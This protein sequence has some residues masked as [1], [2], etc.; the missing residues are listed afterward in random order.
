MATQII[1]ILCEGPHDVAFITRIL[2]HNGYSSNDKSK[3]KDFPAPINGL[4]KTE[5]S[6]T[7]VED[8]NL[9]E[10]RQVL[11]PSNSL[12]IGNNYFLLYS[13]GGD[14]KKAARQQLL[15][16]FY[17][18]IPKE[19]E[20]S[21]MPD[22]TALS[23]LY[24]FDSDDKGIAVRVA[25]L[26]EEILEIL[27]VSPFTN[28]KEKYNH[29]NLNLG[30]FIFSGADNDKG[31]LEDILMPL[32]SLDNDQIFAEASTYLDNNFD[33]GRVHKYDKDKSLIGVVGQLQHSG[34]SNAV[35]VNKSDYINE[36]K[37]KANSKCKEIFDYINSF[38]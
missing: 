36:A 16:D 38:I 4:L 21:T 6:K 9:Q 2:K 24:F 32:M 30:S 3:I 11:L 34:A 5:V 17:S 22:D 28:H 15:S 1:A 18:F 29:F 7:N 33:N 13:M 25:E 35:C 20:I 31:K 23:L 27:E 8:L 19:N 12:V 37:I 26:N 14:S 10:V